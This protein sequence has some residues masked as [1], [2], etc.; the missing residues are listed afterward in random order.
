MYIFSLL[1]EY[2]VFRYFNMR[3]R[4]KQIPAYNKI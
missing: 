3:N 2:S 1:N 4:L